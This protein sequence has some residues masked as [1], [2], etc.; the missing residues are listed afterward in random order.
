MMGQQTSTTKHYQ[1]ITTIKIDPEYFIL[2]T[3]S[4][5]MGRFTYVSKNYQI[6]R[7]YSFE[8]PLI[9]YIEAMTKG[10]FNIELSITPDNEQKV[11]RYETFSP[12]LSSKINSYFNNNHLIID[13]LK[14]LQNLNCSY[15]TGRYYRYGKR[16]NNSIYSI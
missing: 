11:S 4:D 15:L 14:N 3:L 12:E 10:E 8:K 1:K 16:I 7:Y 13:S 6:D 2:G 9:D 5:Y